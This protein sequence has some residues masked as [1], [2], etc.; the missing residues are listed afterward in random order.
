MCVNYS[1]MH[2]DFPKET[3]HYP[4][5]DKLVYKSLGFNLLSFIDTYIGFNKI[6]MDLNDCSLT[7]FMTGV[8]NFYYK[9]IM[10]GP[11][12]VEATC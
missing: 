6:L 4:N 10:F 5:I 11:N 2:W 8:W 12:K 1:N 3:Y 9:V 7:M